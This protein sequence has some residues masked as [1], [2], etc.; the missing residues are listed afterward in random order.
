MSF[1]NKFL[2]FSIVLATLIPT[3]VFS[4][5]LVEPEDTNLEKEI[6]PEGGLTFL[7]VE[8]EEDKI[9]EDVKEEILNLKQKLKNGQINKEE[10]KEELEKLIHD[11]Q[12][13][14]F[15]NNLKERLPQDI[16]ENIDKLK[17]SL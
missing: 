10:F 17:I 1:K 6:E 11:S 13:N 12:K 5:N 7:R 16:K 14:I 3:F 15:K 4:D 8:Q 9:P 2:I